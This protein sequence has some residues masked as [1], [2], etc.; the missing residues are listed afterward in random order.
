MRV[1]FGITI[2][3]FLGAVSR[4]ELGLLVPSGEEAAFPWATLIVNLSG[5]LLLGVLF[6]ITSRRRMP[7]WLTEAI[8]TGFLGSFTTFSAFNGQLWELCQHRAY[9]GAAAYVVV[10]GL[11]GWLLAAGGLAWGRGKPS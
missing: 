2:A 5:S 6:G 4:Y 10:S 1:V 3:G 7:A 8:G 9:F 11:G